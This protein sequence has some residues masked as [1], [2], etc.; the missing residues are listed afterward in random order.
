MQRFCAFVLLMLSVSG[1]LFVPLPSKYYSGPQF[2][3]DALAFLDQAGT[4]RVEVLA[5]LGEPLIELNDPGVLVYVS[6]RTPQ[7]LYIPNTDVFPDAQIRVVDGSV[8][9]RALFIAYDENGFVFAH[10]IQPDGV[11]DLRAS[12][13]TWRRQL[14]E[15]PDN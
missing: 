9:G 2:S 5:T 12:C 7:T 11:T 15:P 10:E 4:T 8:E 13:W 3:R 14:T 1:C 6:Q